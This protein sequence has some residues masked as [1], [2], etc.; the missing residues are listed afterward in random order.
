MKNLFRVFSLF[1]M[2]F[3]TG[4]SV[5]GQEYDCNT[6]NNQFRTKKNQWIIKN[7]DKPFS[8][9]DIS[10]FNGL[11][12]YP[13]DCKYVYKGK[14]TRNEPMKIVN[15]ATSKGGTMQLYDYGTVSCQIGQEEYNLTVYKNIDMPEFSNSPETLFIPFMDETSGPPP[16]TTFAS[17]RYL[18]VQAPAS[19][20]K[21]VLDFNRATNPFE[22][23][24]S[25][26]PTLVVPDPNVIRVPLDTGERKYED[27]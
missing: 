23:Y 11:F 4:I 22:N 9:S 8:A 26:Y 24:N 21:L 12:Y 6:E 2:V 18:I 16:K 1:A 13:T 15:V 14:L 3:L 5:Y 10:A 17:G 27:R 19:G 25:N 7:P 20:N